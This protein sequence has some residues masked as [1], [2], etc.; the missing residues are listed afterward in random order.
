VF[1]STSLGGLG[2]AEG[3]D[4]ASQMPI[5]LAVT[6]FTIVYSAVT[7]WIAFKLASLLCGGLRVSEDE[8]DE[9]LDVTTHGE[10]GYKY[11]T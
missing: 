11:Y 5:Q 1:A 9:G 10:T 8:E 3:R 7:S 6:G 2:F 4:M